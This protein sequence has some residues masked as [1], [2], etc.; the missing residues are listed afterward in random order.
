MPRL[1]IRPEVC[2]KTAAE[3]CAEKN[4]RVMLAF[5]VAREIHRN[6]KRKLTGEPYL[7]HCVAVADILE[8]WGAGED[9]VV[10][11]LLHDTV[12]DHPDLI[13]FKTIEELFG[14]K[15]ARMVDGVTKMKTISGERNEFET[16]RKVTRDSLIE[17]GV[18]M[19][20]LADR[21]HNMKT[22]DALKP[23]RQ[24]IKAKET[25]AVY[26]PLAES[27]GLWQVKNAL[28]DWSFRYLDPLRFEAVSRVID[29][30]PRTKP[31]FI[32]TKEKEIGDYLRSYGLD[33]EVE[34]QVGGYWELA[35]KQRRSS[36]RADTKPKSFFDLTDVVSFRI[37]LSDHNLAGCY[38]AMGILRMKYG[39]ELDN[40]RH[41]DMLIQPATNGY[42]ALHDTYKFKEG[43]VEIAITTKTREKFN[44]WG[45]M[46]L[47]EDELR[48]NPE[49]YARKLV[50]T[51][52]EELV[53]MELSATGIDVA[54]KLSPA[55]GLRAVGMEIDGVKSELSEIV[56]NASM[57]EILVEPNKGVPELDWLDFCDQSTR[58]IIEHQLIIAE[59][60]KEVT[61][62]R[63]Q[64]KH[65]VLRELGILDLNDLEYET[66]DKVLIE[67][68]CWHGLPD[69][70]YKIAYGMDTEA[71]RGILAENGIE[72]GKYSTV[73]VRGKNQ[74][75]VSQTLAMILAV[76][77]ADVRS[78]SERV[79]GNENFVTRTL[80]K[81]SP[82]NKKKIMQQIR[83][84]FPNSEIV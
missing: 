45:V 29:S 77:G 37:L 27:F 12:E 39:Q 23:H 9:V 58:K 49:K 75:G 17:P 82:E 4:E 10:A 36:M 13:S 16:L 63:E 43:N 2:G 62:G 53:F 14:S 51:P 11:G 31:E 21:L 32:M 40:E 68:G 83:E 57:V 80:M 28:Q 8:Q 46:S 15:V 22:L 33:V 50:F 73:E 69:L 52:K 25:L 74:I 78:K 64:L 19:I 47:S 42:S 41:D 71:V 67:L 59:H 66:V 65:E 34:H 54:Y 61:R 38:A 7:N 20:K 48:E 5:E 18:A 35:E 70:Y 72:K 60:D 3:F 30:D 44:N 26:A 79:Y 6:D 81:V 84:Q 55:L 1:E 76:N 24:L 56:P